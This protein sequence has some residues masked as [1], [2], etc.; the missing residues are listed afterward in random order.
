[1]ADRCPA[2]GAD[3]DVRWLSLGGPSH[4][5]G[6]GDRGER[7]SP[8]ARWL[9][10]LAV[11][12]LIW[13]VL[14]V[15]G[16]GP[17]GDDAAPPVRPPDPV[18]TTIAPPSAPRFPP[19]PPPSSPAVADAPLLGEATGL[20]AVITGREAF[21]V[22][23]DQ[24]TVR[25]LPATSIVGAVERG[26][27]VGVGGRVDLWPA[28]FDGTGAVPF[29]T[30]DVDQAWVV[31][32]GTQVWAVRLG[33]GSHRRARL[34]NQAGSVLLD[35]S[36]PPEAWP[37]GALDRGLVLTTPGATVLVDG[38]GVAHELSTGTPFAAAGSTV[39]VAVC[40]TP[41]GALECRYEVLD[42]RGQPMDRPVS[43]EQFAR[44]VAVGAGPRLAHV[45]GSGPDT[46]VAV[47]GVV[48]APVGE[49]GVQALA[50]S[51]DGRWLLAVSGIR[52][53]AVDTWGSGPPVSIEVAPSGMA[54]SSL[55]LVPS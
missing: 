40:D 33:F 22:D 37:V 19:V 18:T 32:G 15:V 27:L 54:A 5:A 6:G 24:A 53:V 35:V 50:W 13:G 1:M 10:V 26:L 21:A 16:G 52:L 49:A 7:R 9:P 8:A 25:A 4:P 41:N 12:A 47:D 34:L 14:V 44:P 20:T 3:P 30:G 23:L 48:V 36:L 55:L 29:T 42:A 11:V 43:G 39:Y 46:A 2:C 38:Q 45:L 28:P 17:A 51:S 31:A